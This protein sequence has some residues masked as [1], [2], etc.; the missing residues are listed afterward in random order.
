[1]KKTLSVLLAFC[2]L[3]SVTAAAVSAEPVVVKEKKRVAMD[4]ETGQVKAAKGMAIGNENGEIK[5]AKGV[6]INRKKLERLKLRKAW[7]LI[8]KL[9]LLRLI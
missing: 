7:S 8:E 3:I 5:A 6:A 1:M 4:S 9:V 2:F